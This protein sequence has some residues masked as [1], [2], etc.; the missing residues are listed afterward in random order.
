MLMYESYCNAMK[1]GQVIALFGKNKDMTPATRNDPRLT[2]D[3][4]T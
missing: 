3:P 4:I 1:H 2:F